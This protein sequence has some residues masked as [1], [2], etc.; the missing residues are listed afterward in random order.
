MKKFIGLWIDKKKA[1]ILTLEEK[2]EQ[3][4]QIQS[5]LEKNVRFRGGARAKTPYGAQFFAAEDQKDRRLG[6]HLKKYY[7][8][9]IADIR[10]AASILIMGPGEAKFE[11]EKQLLHKHTGAKMITVEAA[12]KLTARQFAAKVRRH[13]KNQ[14]L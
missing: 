6:G 1:V 14:S 3:L 7:D 5:N 9:V 12:D 13:F 11:F 2:K 10:D 8:E 4:K